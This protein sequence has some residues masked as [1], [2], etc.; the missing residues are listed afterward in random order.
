MI[1]VGSQV[2]AGAKLC[3]IALELA[4]GSV[5]VGFEDDEG[6]PHQWWIPAKDVKESGRSSPVASR[7]SGVTEASSLELAGAA[8]TA[9]APFPS[10]HCE[11]TADGMV[12]TRF[13]NIMTP[14]EAREFAY[15]K[16]QREAVYADELLAC[17]SLAEREAGKR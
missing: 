13:G 16:R 1:R 5:L 11:Y 6:R 8:E 9:P 4:E 10:G 2:I 7:A 14:A 3:G 12:V 15:I 17:A